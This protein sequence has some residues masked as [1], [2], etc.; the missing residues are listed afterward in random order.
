MQDVGAKTNYTHMYM[1]INSS[2]LNIVAEERLD[3]IALLTSSSVTITHQKHS[4]THDNP[5]I[6]HE[7]P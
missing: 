3:D 5:M 2:W 6:H 7:E 1:H 4:T